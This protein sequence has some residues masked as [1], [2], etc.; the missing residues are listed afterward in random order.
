MS[1]SNGFLLSVGQQ[2]GDQALLG[3]KK[4]PLVHHGKTQGYYLHMHKRKLWFASE[5]QFFETNTHLKS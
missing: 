2:G 3:L 1:M 4:K 5:S